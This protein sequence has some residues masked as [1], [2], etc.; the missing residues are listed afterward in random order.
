MRVLVSNDDG[1]D[2]PGLQTLVATLAPRA[3]V[4]VVAPMDEQSAKSHAITLHS[5]LRAEQRG[6]QRYAV[7]GTPADCVY[8]GLHSLMPERPHLVISGINR[9][10]NL[11]NDVHYSGTVAAAREAALHGLPAIAVSL[12]LLPE[13]GE[14]IHFDTAAFVALQVF[15][16]VA[17]SGLPPRTLLNVNVP[18]LP[19]DQLAG[20]RAATLGH[21]TYEN[22]VT[23][24]SDPFGRDYFWIGG[25]HVRFDNTPR[26]DGPL[27]EEGFATVTPLHCDPTLHSYLDVLRDRIDR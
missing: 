15:E 6:H 18:N 21:R 16:A 22:Q 24:R 8:L 27:V 4:W 12:H 20:I 25:P 11:G 23:R 13:G 10:S 19:R 9:G 5:P 1:F 7:G 26:S 2:A 17:N 3:D 14:A